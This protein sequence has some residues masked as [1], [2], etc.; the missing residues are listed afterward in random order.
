M[1]YTT[2][3]YILYIVIQRSTKDCLRNA[4]KQLFH[5]NEVLHDVEAVSI[6]LQFQLLAALS[7]HSQVAVLINA[8][9]CHLLIALASQLHHCIAAMSGAGVEV[10][11]T[12]T[13]LVVRLP[14]NRPSLWPVQ[15]GLL[16]HQS[17]HL[18]NLFNAHFK[19][20]TLISRYTLT[21]QCYVYKQ[22]IYHG[23]AGPHNIS[24]QCIVIV[25]TH[26]VV[27]SKTTAPVQ[28]IYIHYYNSR[29][30]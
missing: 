22:S 19:V 17:T 9:H 20:F 3:V 30:S 11:Q 7:P 14:Q 10:I 21:V 4:C 24:P 8:G 6:G 23:R 28:Y 25:C 15:A 1:L 5:N 2:H 18:L 26:C 29:G 13:Y 12:K 16:P 27:Y